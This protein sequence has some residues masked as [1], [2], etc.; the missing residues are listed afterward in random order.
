MGKKPKKEAIK[1]EEPKKE[2]AKP[3]EVKKEAV[4][5]AEQKGTLTKAK[6]TV[7]KAAGK[8]VAAVA[9]AAEVV[10]AHVVPP[11]VVI[12]KP[13]RKRFVREKK[14]KVA[15]PAPANLPE[16]STKATAKLMTKGLALPPKEDQATGQK[17]RA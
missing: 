12:E 11:P 10:Q 7:A 5:P 16:R 13:K 4:K 14:E 2:A 1:P 6:E 17:P 3:A 15:P 8:V 9:H